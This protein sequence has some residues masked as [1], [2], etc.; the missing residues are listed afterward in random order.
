MIPSPRTRPGWL[1][2]RLV[3]LGAA[4][5]CAVL[6]WHRVPAME[7]TR[8]LAGLEP[9]SA[10]G[11]TLIS[12]MRGR[13]GASLLIMITSMLLAVTTGL[14]VSLCVLR[15][16]L[17]LPS[18]IALV[19]RFLSAMPV[20]AIAW[21]AIGV[22]VGHQG[23]PIESLLPHHPAQDRDTWALATGRELWWWLAPSWILALPLMGELVFRAIE[24]FRALDH[25]HFLPALQ[26]RGLHRSAI[27]YRHL[28]PNV[29][30]HLLDC[31]ESLGLLALGYLVLVKEALGIPG[32]G[33]FL[34]IAMQNGDARGVAASI[35]AACWLGG[36]WCLLIAILRRFTVGRSG[37]TEPVETPHHHQSHD[38]L[39]T[40][41]MSLLLLVLACCPFTASGTKSDWPSMLASF[42]SPLVHDLG[43]AAGGCG[44]ALAITLV[45]G[46]ACGL[47]KRSNWLSGLM[48][49]FAWSPTLVWFLALAGF[50]AH[51]SWLVLGLVAAPGGVVLVAR[52]WR[53]IHASGFM[54]ASLSVGAGRLHAWRLHVMPEMFRLIL[55][56]VLE[57][58]GTMLV[59]LSLIDSLRS[60]RPER[61]T[62]LGQAISAAKENVL[63]DP[64]PLLIPAL[65]VAICALF[66]RQLSL[67][68]R[69]GPPPH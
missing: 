42:A 34:A 39:T 62:S 35:Y 69:P 67:I 65:I 3:I 33:S 6:A 1:P 51:A 15:I 9:V 41:V 4:M 16:G 66:F 43:T 58:F 47:T 31:I 26:S 14:A 54:E 36:A 27:R 63:S 13:A 61:A 57:T 60:A 22:V 19:G 21:T 10:D 11:T 8:F 50:A 56:W 17:G 38:M 53:E 12:A 55:A 45:L 2:L 37:G 32:W 48:T 24:G 44:L 49:T 68:V 30:P 20:V 52:R 25:S 59:W 28:L 64:Q 5:A 7:W 29:W 23:W 40:T 18:L 46:T